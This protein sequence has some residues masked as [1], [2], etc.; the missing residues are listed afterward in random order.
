M[1]QDIMSFLLFWSVDMSFGF[2]TEFKITL[3]RGWLHRRQISSLSPN[4]L[5]LSKRNHYL[6][7]SLLHHWGV[8]SPTSQSRKRRCRSPASWQLTP[9]ERWTLWAGLLPLLGSLCLSLSTR[10]AAKLAVSP[11]L[12]G[13]AHML[14]QRGAAQT[15]PHTSSRSAYFKPQTIWIQHVSLTLTACDRLREQE[16]EQESSF[17][18][19]NSSVLDFFLCCC[20]FLRLTVGEGAHRERLCVCV[21]VSLCESVRE[22]KDQDDCGTATSLLLHW[23]Q[24]WPGQK[25]ESRLPPSLWH[26]HC[27]PLSACSCGGHWVHLRFEHQNSAV[28]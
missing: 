2:H 21:W 14:R 3:F 28:M 15:K 20:C 22:E 8:T 26:H 4:V 7:L 1:F 19:F 6:P 24:R 11:M 10:P 25:G 5:P 16:P 9:S 27:L 12:P 13:F 17:L 23:T 18:F